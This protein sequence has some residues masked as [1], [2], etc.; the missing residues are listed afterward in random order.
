LH[1]QGFSPINLFFLLLQSFWPFAV[2]FRA[3]SLII[4]FII[5]FKTKIYFFIFVNFFILLIFRTFWWTE[6]HN[7][8]K[9]GNHTLLSLD[10]LKI[11]ILLFILREVCF[12]GGFFWR[13]FHYSFV[14]A[15]DIGDTW[16]PFNLVAINPFSVPLLN[17]VVLVRRGATITFSHINLIFNK[18]AEGSLFFTLFLGAYFTFL[19]GFEYYHRPFTI[20]DSTYGSTFFIATGFHGI[21]VLVGSFFLFVCLLRFLNNHFSIINHLGY[22]IAIW[23]WHFVDVVWLFLFSFIYWW[24]Y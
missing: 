12:F 23:Y 7:E 13:F 22:E 19:Q 8:T 18:K 5:F 2:S 11:G 6:V 14:P 1:L 9:I 17:T 15:G 16:P 4:S 24:R 20:R 10:N 3:I 21:H